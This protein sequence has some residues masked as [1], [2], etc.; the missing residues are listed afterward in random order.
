MAARQKRQAPTIGEITLPPI[1]A[2]TTSGGMQVL[3]ARREPIPLVSV[4]LILRS[5]SATDPAGRNGLADFTARLMRRGTQKLTADAIN[6]A[7]E[8][9]G[10]SLAAGAVEDYTALTLTTPARHL[11]AMMAIVGQL[12]TEPAFT[13]SEVE[14]AR[15][16]TLAQLANDLDDPGAVADRAL[17]KVIWG[18]HPYGHDPS[19]T[20]RDVARFTREDV[21]AFH[22]NAYGPKLATLVIVGAVDPKIARRAVESAFASW[23]G[24]PD[25]PVQVP[26]VERAAGAGRV[27]L[28][29][30]P[31]QSQSQVRIASMGLRRGAPG[32][33][34]ASVMNTT[35]GGGFT[36]RL[37]NEIRVNRGLSYGAGSMFDGMLGGGSFA[38]STFTKTESTA[39]IIQVALD[40]V[41]KMRE[42]GPS[43]REL[44]TAR[45]YLAGLYPLR[46]ETNESVAAAI[47]ETRIYNLGD[48]WVSSYRGR[49][50]AVTR[51]E[52]KEAARRYLPDDAPALVVVGKADKVRRQLKGLGKIDVRSVSDFE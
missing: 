34:A 31:D 37:V 43:T 30:K 26:E 21:L 4:R 33:I 14:S 50:R 22:R 8:F 1:E 29:D 48:D 27:L 10:A 2:F 15:R 24:G 35:L 39:E 12:I 17:A 38:I 44:E 51:A 40:E 52:A 6:D 28:V 36:S 45:T 7:V 32:W 9:V 19:G 13:E 16:R 47:A 41:R 42:K 23:R 20:Q 11:E 3:L 18:E 46:L 49:I 25:S 5:G